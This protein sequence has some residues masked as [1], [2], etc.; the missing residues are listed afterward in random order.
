[1]FIDIEKEKILLAYNSKLRLHIKKKNKDWRNGYVREIQAD[2]FL[3]EDDQNGIE[4]IFWIELLKVD[5]YI[6]EREIKVEVEK[7]GG[8]NAQ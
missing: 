1:M 7:D 2:F 4:P 8:T 6:N 5:P 3:F